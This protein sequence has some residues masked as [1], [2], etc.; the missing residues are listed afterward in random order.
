MKILNPEYKDDVKYFV[1]EFTVRGENIKAIINS[2]DYLPAALEF[3]KY[4]SQ[5]IYNNFWG[6]VKTKITYSGW[7]ITASG[8]K[9]PSRWIISSEGFPTNDIA[10]TELEMNP[11]VPADTFKIPDKVK[12]TFLKQKPKNRAEFA[13]DNNNGDAN[14]IATGI[15]QSPGIE[16]K[17]NS[18]IVK[19]SDGILIIDAPFSSAN[20]KI[21]IQKANELFPGE[22]IKA[23]VS[24]NQL[25]MHIAG[26]REYAADGIP[27]YLYKQNKDIVEKLMNAKYLTEPD[28]LQKNK[29][30]A[31]IRVISSR[32]SLGEGE[33]RIE[34]I[35]VRTGTGQRTMAVYF[36]EKQLLYASDLYQPKR[37]ARGFYSYYVNEIKSLVER[38]NLDVEK[39]YSLHMTPIKYADLIKQ[40]NDNK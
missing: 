11:A 30:E 18:T 19:Q 39:I 7:M 29:K 23:V 9:F 3:T 25:W 20:S 5:D 13:K 27:I 17:Y 2:L 35:P 22:K 24:S 32:T 4:D 21:V 10:F 12:E 16:T 15:Y 8:I 38:E 6:D 1:L 28:K 40:L 14:L 31:V 26:L 36:P 33:N 37:F 34:I